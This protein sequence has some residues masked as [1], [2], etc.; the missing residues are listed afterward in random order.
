MR[1]LEI[2]PASD[3]FALGVVLYRLL[4]G[5]SPYS[6]AATGSDFTLGQAICD[7]EPQAPS[8][9]SPLGLKR[10]LRGDLDAMALMALRKDPARRYASAEAFADDVVAVPGTSR[11]VASPASV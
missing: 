1:G 7:T 10:G 5:A 9:S 6:A 3:V 11:T 8:R 4:T 2:T